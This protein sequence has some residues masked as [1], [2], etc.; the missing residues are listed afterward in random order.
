MST[1]KTHWNLYNYTASLTESKSQNSTFVVLKHST[2]VLFRTFS[3]STFKEYIDQVRIFMDAFKS[4]NVIIIYSVLQIDLG[5]CYQGM[6][7]CITIDHMLS[8]DKIYPKE[9]QLLQ[10]WIH[11]THSIGKH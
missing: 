7:T 6:S 2:F 10:P 8:H 1:D 5:T 11:L 3:F 9:L 4:K